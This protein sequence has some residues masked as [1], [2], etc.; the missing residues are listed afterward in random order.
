MSRLHL[1]FATW[2]TLVI[3][4]L[5]CV[6]HLTVNSIR[7]EAGSAL[8]HHLYH[9]G[10]FWLQ[11]TGDPT[12]AELSKKGLFLCP[13]LEL[14]WGKPRFR[15]SECYPDLIS[16]PLLVPFHFPPCVGFLFRLLMMP[17]WLPPLLPQMISGRS[18][19]LFLVTKT[20]FSRLTWIGL[21]WLMCPSLN[22]SL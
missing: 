19:P 7:P 18:K 1:T 8:V 13:S 3:L 11:G 17:R 20:K 22:Q 15:G 6:P 9:L 5:V 12:Q 10:A 21:A 16:L 2:V 14:A 4:C